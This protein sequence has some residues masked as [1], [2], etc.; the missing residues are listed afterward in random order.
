VS[1]ACS[2]NWTPG[3]DCVPVERNPGGSGRDQPPA[4]EASG[5]LRDDFTP[6]DIVLLLMANAGLIDRSGPARGQTCERLVALALDGFRAQGATEAPP[7]PSPKTLIKA[8][9]SQAP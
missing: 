9:R 1:P 7:A 6:E 8:L 4:D 5:N 2:T 3:T